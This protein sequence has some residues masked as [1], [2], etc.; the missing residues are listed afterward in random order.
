MT[1]YFA[2]RVLLAAIMAPAALSA[3]G[4]HREL[5][6]ACQAVFDGNICT[7]GTMD[8]DQLIEFGATIPMSTIEN[9]PLEGEFVFPPVPNAIIPLPE[10]V[11]RITGFD[12]LS[13][14][15]E[16]QGHPP[17]LFLTP[18]FDFHFYTIT[19]D[20]A[21]WIDCAEVAK[22]VQ[23]PMGYSLPDVEVPDMGTLIGI[24]VPHMGMHAM[25]TKEVEETAPFGASMLVGYYDRD[26]IFLEPM[27]SHAKLAEAK[28]FSMSVPQLPSASSNVRWPTQY[29]AVYNPQTREY[30]FVFS[31]L[32]SG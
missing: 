30:R 25:R 28:T 3:C 14:Y 4:G 20:R 19:P 11:T 23:L 9:A 5:S 12:H 1:R 6:G 32:P 8:G 17:A 27:I 15:W 21:R 26:L 22:P 24:C 29:E 2:Y 18:H 13:V 7:W 16:V 10:E 31:G